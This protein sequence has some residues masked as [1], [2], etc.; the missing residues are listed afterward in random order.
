MV[1]FGTKL[2]ERPCCSVC[3][4]LGVIAPGMQVDDCEY[5]T[6]TRLA[7]ITECHRTITRAD[8]N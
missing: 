5:F 4:F 7:R 3:C 8:K 2:W 6:A 1:S